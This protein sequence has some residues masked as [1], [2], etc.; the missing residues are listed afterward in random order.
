[1]IFNGY[2][3][4]KQGRVFSKT[5]HQPL[6]EKEKIRL[7]MSPPNLMEIFLMMFLCLGE[8]FFPRPSLC[9]KLLTKVHND[10]GKKN[11][12]LKASPMGG[13][14]IYNDNFAPSSITSKGIN[15]NGCSCLQV[16]H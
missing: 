9:L 15:S 10:H 7:I 6:F 2:H 8:G 12:N 4:K 5:K 13:N 3:I 1:M 11:H 16:E 14:K